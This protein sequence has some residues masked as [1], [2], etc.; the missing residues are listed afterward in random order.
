MRA[1]QDVV[2][3]VVAEPALRHAASDRLLLGRND[4][5]NVA[6][7]EPAIHLAIGVTLVGRRHLNRYAGRRRDS[8]D[9]RQHVIALG[10]LAR[11][12]FH[13]EHDAEHV[14]HCRVLLVGGL[15]AQLRAF[16]AIVASGSVKQIF[17]CLPDCL[18]F[19]SA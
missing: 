1:F 13:V 3:C 16:V 15:Q 12:D 6:P 10:G 18:P 14:V 7:L 4:R 19:R 17:S 9:L 5:V 2:L 8:I 11:R